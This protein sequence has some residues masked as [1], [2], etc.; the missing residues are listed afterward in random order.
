[1]LL[2]EESTA[3]GRTNGTATDRY[4]CVLGERTDGPVASRMQELGD[5]PVR[6]CCADRERL[7]CH[8]QL[9]GLGSQPRWRGSC[10]GTC[11]LCAFWKLLVAD[12]CVSC[13]V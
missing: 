4:T 1:M 3:L 11:T 10:A 2:A 8:E 6:R 7:S 12:T 5:F 9:L 13:N